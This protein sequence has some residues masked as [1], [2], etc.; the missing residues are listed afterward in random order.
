MMLSLSCNYLLIFSLLEYNFF[1]NHTFITFQST[2]KYLK[3][4]IIDSEETFC[5][6]FFS[7]FSTP[8]QVI[9][10]FT[11]PYGSGDIGWYTVSEP[12]VLATKRILVE[13]VQSKCYFYANDPKYIDPIPSDIRDS[14]NRIEAYEKIYYDPLT[15][16]SWNVR[17]MWP[18]NS[19]IY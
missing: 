11:E 4:H 1:I 14:T 3:R 13:E 19:G 5:I 10:T 2:P 7:T 17:A 12:L 18:L 8:S 15:A 16:P 9:E 6:I